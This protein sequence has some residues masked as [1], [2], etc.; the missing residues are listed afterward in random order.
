MPKSSPKHFAIFQWPNAPLSIAI[1]GW[2]IT[3]FSSGWLQSLSL[4]VYLISLTAWA[5]WELVS[6]V[7]WFRRTLGGVVLLM[8]LVH[9]VR[10]IWF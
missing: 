7:N 10:L 9:V 1:I 5:A 2:F 8:T 6:G 3:R 4:V